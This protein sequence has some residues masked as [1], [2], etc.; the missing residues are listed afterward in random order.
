M[1]TKQRLAAAREA[2]DGS[3][4]AYRRIKAAE[5]SYGR[6]RD[7]WYRSA[8]YAAINGRAEVVAVIGPRRPVSYMEAV[9]WEAVKDGRF[10]LAYGRTLRAV[11]ANI[12]Q[13][14]VEGKI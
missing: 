8:Y 7:N 6:G 11:K 12:E 13:L 10:V 14:E 5:R 9:E 2:M 3:R 4:L 1:T